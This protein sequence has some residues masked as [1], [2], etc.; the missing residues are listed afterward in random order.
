MLKQKE[1]GKEIISGPLILTLSP[2]G[3]NWPKICQS[4]ISTQRVKIMTKLTKEN[5]F[6]SVESPETLPTGTISSGGNQVHFGG[7]Q[8][9]RKVISFLGQFILNFL[10]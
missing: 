3:S 8:C 9:L 5:A 2:M 4:L 6:R 7:R 1:I 10:R